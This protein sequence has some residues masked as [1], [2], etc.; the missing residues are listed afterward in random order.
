MPGLI[1]DEGEAQFLAVLV[2]GAPAESLILRLY[3]N[4][5]TPGLGDSA[6]DYV[7]MA[8]HGYAPKLLGPDDWTITPAEAGTNTPARAQAALQTFVFPVAGPPDLVHGYF[9]T[10]ATSG[11][12]YGAG[13]REP[14]I[15]V[16]NAG[17][18]IEVAP[19]LRLR[20]E[21]PS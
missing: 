14:P 19:M 4:E 18:E 10:G 1:P 21:Y 11:V 6:S 2:A 7:E 9:L 12:L 16:E 15:P 8:S 5:H 17:H 13:D 20:S 3:V